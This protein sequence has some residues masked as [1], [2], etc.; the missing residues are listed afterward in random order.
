MQDNARRPVFI[1]PG[2]ERSHEVT[3]N[4]WAVIVG[5][6]YLFGAPRP[7]SLSAT[8]HPPFIYIYAVG[9]VVGG[10]L[11][12]AGCFWL[13]DLERSLEL[14]RA[15]LVTL[16]GMLLIYVAAVFTVTG[17]PGLFAA[18]LVGAWAWANVRRAVQCTRDLHRLREAE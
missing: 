1:V 6:F 8:L 5:V 7:T 18:G 3:L 15:G 9:L 17:Y 2:R 14:E 10:L 11:T 12:L 4:L 16:T 13:T